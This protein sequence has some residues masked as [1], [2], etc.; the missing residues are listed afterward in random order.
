MPLL[1]NNTISNKDPSGS[2]LLYFWKLLHSSQ[3]QI[4]P[5]HQ[6]MLFMHC[7]ADTDSSF[8]SSQLRTCHKSLAHSFKPWIISWIHFNKDK[9]YAY[10]YI[11][12]VIDRPLNKMMKSHLPNFQYILHHPDIHLYIIDQIKIIQTQFNTLDDKIL[13]N[14]RLNL[15][16]Y[17][18]FQQKLQMLLSNRDIWMCANLNEQQLDDVIEFFMD[19][20][21]DKDKDIHEE[22]ALSIAKIALKLNERQLNKV[23]ECLMND[24]E[25]EKITICD[26]CARALATISS[27]LGGKQLDNASQCFIHRFP[28]YFYN[29]YYNDYYETNATQFLMKLKEEQLGDVFQCLI[30][31]LSDEK[32]AENK[33]IKCAKLLGKFSMKWNEKQL[34]DAFNSLKD[35][36]NKD[37]DWKYRE[38]LGTITVKLSGKQFDNAFNYFISR[39][40]R[41][42]GH[43]Y[44]DLL[45]RIAQRLDEKQMNIAL[46]YIFTDKNDSAHVR[47]EYVELLETIAANLNGKHFDD[48]FQYFTNGLKDSYRTVRNSCAKS[49]VTLSKKWNDKQLDI[50]VQCLIDGF[51]NING[52]HCD[53]FVYLLEGIAMKLNETQIDSVFTCLINGLKGNNEKN[54]KLYTESIRYVSIKLNKKQLDDVFKCLNDEQLDRVFSSFIHG[55]KDTINGI[56]NHVQNYLLFLA[57]MSGLKDNNKNVRESFVNVLMSGLKYGN[58][59]IRILC[60]KSLGVVSE[61]LDEKQLEDAINTLIDELKDEE[62]YS[63]ELCAK[64]F[65][66]LW[67]CGWYW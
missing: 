60:A 5:I 14:D 50:A 12:R 8:L 41:E 57:L 11:F 62:D 1:Y 59:C 54:R 2:G 67:L 30:D 66:A 13:I 39:S 24:F 27:Q 46:N 51:Q 40:N 20:L 53:T 17:F 47:G 33:R 35:M 10:D 52:Y 15:L 63:R 19:R 31:R 3:P 38:S 43:R 21:V 22:C 7:K 45:Y 26:K 28:S 36:S 25:S 6:M 44:C 34:N 56:V 58:S 55:L 61:K 29:D 64:S 16:Q 65:G 37:D 23:F 48:A 4:V 18:L 32:E 49:L 42:K 9:D